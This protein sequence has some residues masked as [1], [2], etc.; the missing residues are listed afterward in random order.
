VSIAADSV[1]IVRAHMNTGGYGGAAFLGSVQSG[2]NE[3]DL[4]PDFAVDL[5]NKPPLPDDCAF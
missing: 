5:A 4:D 3:T 2:F 1:V